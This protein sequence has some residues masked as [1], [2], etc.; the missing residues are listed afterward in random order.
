MEQHG[1]ADADGDAVD[2]GDDRLDVMRQ[3][4]EEP[5]RVRRPRLVRIRRAVLEEILEVVAGGEDAGAAGDDEAADVRIV[6]R[7]VDGIAHRAVHLLRDRVLLFRPPQRDHTHG[8]FVGN[9]E[10]LGHTRQSP[11][12][13]AATVPLA[14]LAAISYMIPAKAQAPGQGPNERTIFPAGRYEDI[15]M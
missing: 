14:S 6:L 10:V 15:A 13:P 12:K 4:I 7:G 3:R 8:M 11:E 5:C 2:G 1:G 9:D